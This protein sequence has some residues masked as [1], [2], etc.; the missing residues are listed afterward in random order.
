MYPP[1]CSSDEPKFAR[2]RDFD[3]RF[4]YRNMLWALPVIRDYTKLPEN[5]MIRIRFPDGG[6]DSFN[7]RRQNGK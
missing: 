2:V 3:N 1:L 4:Q 6:T 7:R 5:N